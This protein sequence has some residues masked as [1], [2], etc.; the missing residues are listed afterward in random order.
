MA[1]APSVLTQAEAADVLRA[2]LTALEGGTTDID[3][4]GL[5]RF[6]SSAVATLVAWRRAAMARGVSLQIDGMPEGLQSLVRLYGVDPLL[7]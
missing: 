6:D 3:L 2:G 5:Q 4:S 1:F 7:R